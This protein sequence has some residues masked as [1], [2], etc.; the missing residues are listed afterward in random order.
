MQQSWRADHDKLTFI[1]C[2]PLDD[3][4]QE[5]VA[6]AQDSPDRMIGDVNL[7]LSA[8]DDDVEGC[9]GELELMI[10]HSSLRRRGYGRAALLVFLHYI[11]THSQ[12]ILDE[13]KRSQSVD[14]MSL[15]QLNVKIGSQNESSIR[16]FE[17][18][19]FLQ[20][21]DG[22]NYFGEIEFALDG[23]I[24]EGKTTGLLQKYGI[25]DYLELPYIEAFR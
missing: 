7:F 14:K 22:P 25:Q 16:L 10:A 4:P 8:A 2:L 5:I 11:A 17:S 13:Y 21:G 15:R 9:V 19:G 20:L 24:S 12:D 23:L 1:A 18:I 3:T 6:G